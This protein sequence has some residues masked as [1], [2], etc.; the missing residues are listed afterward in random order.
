MI[1]K[2]E[3]E[4]DVCDDPDHQ[5]DHHYHAPPTSETRFSDALI[6]EFKF[7]D[8]K[9]KWSIM[10]PDTYEILINCVPRPEKGPRDK[11]NKFPPWKIEYSVFT[12]YRKDDNE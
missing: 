1:D 10:D 2:R 3:S 4:I 12:K 5:H 11:K 7:P 8:K 6:K 9:I